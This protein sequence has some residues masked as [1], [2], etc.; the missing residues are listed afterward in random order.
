MAK[1]L[2]ISNAFFNA[3]FH[4]KKDA[5]LKTFFDQKIDIFKADSDLYNTFAIDR[6]N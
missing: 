6:F 3:L 2:G 5:N 4:N 1:Y